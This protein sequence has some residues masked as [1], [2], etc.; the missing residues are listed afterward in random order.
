MMLHIGIPILCVAYLVVQAPTTYAQTT[1]TVLSVGCGFTNTTL[2]PSDT[3]ELFNNSPNWVGDTSCTAPTG[4][5]T[6]STTPGTGAPDGAA[7]PNLN[8]TAMANA[9]NTWILQQ[10]PQSELVGL[11]ATIVASAQ[12]S[13]VSPFLI[14]AIAHEESSLASP[15]DFNVSHGNNSFGREAGPGQPSFQGANLWY[16]WTS[17]KASVDYTAPENQGA[18]GGGDI[19]SY[20]RNQYGSKIDTNN[21]VALMEAYAPPSGNNT[22]GYIANI[23]AWTTAL[24]NLT[25]GTPSTGPSGTIPNAA[26]SCPGSTA[27]V[28]CTGGTSSTST[29]SGSGTSTTNTTN[30]TTNTTTGTGTTGTSATSGLSIVRQNVVCIAQKELALW[31]SQPGYPWNGTNTYSETG[32]LKY[33]QNRPEEWCSDFA[34]WVFDQAG[35]PLRPDP[36]WNIAYV[37]NVQAVG[38]QNGNFH[39]HPEA[40]YVP[41]PGDLAIH[42]ADHINIVVTVTGTNITLIGGDQGNGPYPGGSIVS[43][44]SESS[45]HGG[46]ITG[47]VSPD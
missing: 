1:C 21:L 36:A 27:T 6:L 25:N 11:G 32:Y 7:F 44:E 4:S 5:T 41:K 3:F 45:F 20:L 13:N 47:Y 18:V 22:A 33:S 29:G 8:P 28:N 40:S 24:V 35:Y 23:Q 17:V 38:E 26:P 46:G 16:K 34:T 30:T 15:S 31:S 37:P 2:T 10:N 12:H 43:T 14:V 9:I 42:G 19:A 39:W